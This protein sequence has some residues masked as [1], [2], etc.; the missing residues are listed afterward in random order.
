MSELARDVRKIT[1]FKC[2]KEG[3]L[4]KDFEFHYTEP[5]YG[6][7]WKCKNC[8]TIVTGSGDPIPITIGPPFYPREGEEWEWIPP[9]GMTPPPISLKRVKC[10]KCGHEFEVK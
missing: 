2:G 1:C 9:H 7:A 4:Y 8:G 10:P 6:D 3:E 5:D